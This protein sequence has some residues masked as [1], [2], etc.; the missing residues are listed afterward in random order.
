MQ[1]NAQKPDSKKGSTEEDE[2]AAIR[3]IVV[4]CVSTS[5]DKEEKEHLAQSALQNDL[6]KLLGSA[7]KPV[8][9][10]KMDNL[11]EKL[12]GLAALEETW[13]AKARFVRRRLPSSFLWARKQ[14]AEINPE[15]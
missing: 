1:K 9:G 5:P 7:D 2:N 11:S 14:P 13:A 12:G 10:L 6:K 8:E 15:K 3:Q 4:D